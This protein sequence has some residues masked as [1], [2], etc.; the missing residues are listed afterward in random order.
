MI[1]RFLSVCSCSLLLAA[2]APAQFAGP[3]LSWATSSGTGTRSFVPTCT[4]LPVAMVPGDV[5]TLSVWGDYGAPF[6]LFASLGASQCLPIPGIGNG[7][8][9]DFPVVTITF[10]TLTLV[11]P[12]LSCPPAFADLPLVVPALPPGTSVSFQAA[13]SGNG[14]LAFTT[15]ITATV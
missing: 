11:T 12:C 15:A 8:V 4:S 2:A 6:G 9:L 3:G 13:T 5:V 1:H 7:L 14:N 10:G